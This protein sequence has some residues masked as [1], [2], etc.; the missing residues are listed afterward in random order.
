MYIQ[1]LQATSQTK[2]SNSAWLEL[3]ALSSSA[4]T[5]TKHP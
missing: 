1:M 2:R 3:V 4:G 5:T